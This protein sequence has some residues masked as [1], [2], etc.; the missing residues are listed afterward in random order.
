M[1]TRRILWLILCLPLAACAST[2]SSPNATPTASA[3]TAAAASAIVLR[4]APDNLG[5][6]SIGLDYTSV[7]FRIDPAAAEPVS[8]VTDKGVPMMTYWAAGFVP[9][10]A[11]ERVVLDAQGQVVVADGDVLPASQRLKGYYVCF[12]PTS[13]YVLLKEP[14]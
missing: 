3:T 13:L 9:G 4:P 2:A 8:A 14:S 6:D 5:C 10:T 11:A 12:G 7:T 1:M